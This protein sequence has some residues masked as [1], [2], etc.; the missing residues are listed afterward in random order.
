LGGAST[1]ERV[2]A[3]LWPVLSCATSL[4]DLRRWLDE[5]P[6]TTTPVRERRDLGLAADLHA[7]RARDSDRGAQ[8]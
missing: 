3:N 1:F 6:E 8:T 2:A 4:N 7:D 5:S